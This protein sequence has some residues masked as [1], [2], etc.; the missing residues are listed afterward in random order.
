M[1]LLSSQDRETIRGRLAAIIH[2]VRLLFFT[3]TIGEPPTALAMRQILDEVASINSSILVE[4]VNFIL[5]KERAAAYGIEAIPAVVLLRGEEDSRLRFLGA[6]T[7]YEFMSLVEALVL[8][9]TGDSGLSPGNGQLITERVT[10]PVD[11]KVFVTPTCPHCPRMVTLAHRV[12]THSPHVRAACIEATEFLE[13]SR[14][15]RVTGVPKTVV[16][17]TVE[18]LGALDEDAFV[19]SIVPP[20]GVE[21]EPA[22]SA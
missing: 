1:A 14:R 2:P 3:Q 13:L 17:D 19:R 21:D 9:G 20:A 4:E 15:Y 8:A 12:A 7:G 6:P 22:P 18:V 10:S 11:I 16:N 5:D